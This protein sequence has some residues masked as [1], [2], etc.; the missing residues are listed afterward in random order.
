[1]RKTAHVLMSVACLA[2]VYAVTMPRL[3]AQ[4][5][6][7]SFLPSFNYT[8]TGIWN[9]VSHVG[10]VIGTNTGPAAFKIN[11]TAVYEVSEGGN[12]AL[13]GSN[14]TSVTMTPLK[15]ID[16]CSVTTVGSGSVTVDPLTY[17]VVTTAVAGRL[18]IYAWKA[19][20]TND[21]TQVASSSTRQV[22]Y[23]CVGR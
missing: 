13:G 1:M 11:G 14:P 12:T 8:I 16:G 22:Q 21:V 20:A 10:G 4:G 17:T 5:G 6:G 9:F 7:G 3:G 19:N 2:L 18:D 15:T 23:T